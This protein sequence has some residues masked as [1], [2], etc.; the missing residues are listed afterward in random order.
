MMMSDTAVQLDQ[1]Q[2]RKTFNI[3]EKDCCLWESVLHSSWARRV[4]EKS[5]PVSV[6]AAELQDS[7]GRKRRQGVFA[8]I[9]VPALNLVKHDIIMDFVDTLQHGTTARRSA[10]E[11]GKSF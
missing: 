8:C 5:S 6:H 3:R 11:E 4:L 2:V 1:R 7:R 10:S 9:S